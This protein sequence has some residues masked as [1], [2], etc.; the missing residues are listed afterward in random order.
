MRKHPVKLTAAVIAAILSV[1]VILMAVGSLA[2]AAL[3]APRPETDH[4]G[5][6]AAI[7]AESVL[8]P[9]LVIIAALCMLLCLAYRSYRKQKA[10]AEKLKETTEQLQES[11]TILRYTVEHDALTSLINRQSAI[12]LGSR[13]VESGKGYCI[14]MADID[15]FKEINE[16]YGHA[17]GDRVLVIISQ[18][19]LEKAKEYGWFCAR[20]GG[21]EFLVLQPEHGLDEGCREQ[22]ALFDVFREPVT[23]GS[24]RVLPTVSFGFVNGRK[25]ERFAQKIIDADLAMNQAKVSGKNTHFW[26]DDAMRGSV[27]EQNSLRNRIVDAVQNDG[28][29]MVYQ[30]QVDLHTGRQCGFE[31]L[32][33][34]KDF[35]ISPGR[36]I[37]VAERS[38]WIGVIGRIIT[39]KV[40]CQIAEWKAQGETLYPVS[41][42]YS[43]G[44]MHDTGYAD[45]L[46]G[47]LNRYQ[48]DPAFV[49]I[50]ITES[51]FMNNTHEVLDLLGR[52]RKMGL[53]LLIDDFGT[54][55]S[56]FGYLSYLPV[57]IIKIDKSI[58]DAYLLPDKRSFVADLIR[59]AHDLGKYVIQ[60]G[61]EEA[62][63]IQMLKE[64]GCDCVQG[65]FYSRPVPAGEAIRFEVSPK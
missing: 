31:A 29:Y 6:R 33:R 25:E 13:A 22:Q 55:Y 53:K 39:Q 51:M 17:N 63:Q 40:I 20:Y 11:E 16:V 42:N 5:T 61:I 26:F 8:I 52:F 21:D 54:G 45:Y 23:I 41:I 12:P 7:E 24:D 49:E 57:D 19:L 46:Q 15:N 64:M 18:R 62:D 60:E 36:F 27:E 3:F 14:C 56:S 47:L 30:P 44:Q 1:C 2:A 4:A 38:G 32:V 37:P 35:T 59:I 10:I 9:A 50:E 28:F 48:V 65:Y 58:A 34:M 43:T